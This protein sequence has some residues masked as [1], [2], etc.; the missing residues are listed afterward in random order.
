MGFPKKAVIAALKQ[1]NNNMDRALQALHEQPDLLMLGDSDDKPWRGEVTNDMIAQ[2]PNANFD[3]VH[4]FLYIR[5]G[6]DL[7]RWTKIA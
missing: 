2:V 7:S 3:I 6:L 4:T 5:G 1:T